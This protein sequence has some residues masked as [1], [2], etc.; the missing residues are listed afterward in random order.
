MAVVMT[1]LSTIYEYNWRQDQLEFTRVSTSP[2]PAQ[3]LRP[4]TRQFVPLLEVTH[5][6]TE[7]EQPF[8]ELVYESM[9]CD[10]FA[11]L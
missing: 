11:A 3:K 1:N 8:S 5:Q 9:D 6:Q 7:V 4:I 10:Y 2:I